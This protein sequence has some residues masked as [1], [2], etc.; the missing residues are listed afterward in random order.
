MRLR[1]PAVGGTETANVVAFLDQGRWAGGGRRR[2]SGFVTRFSLESRPR[3]GRGGLPPIG[4]QEWDAIRAV[5]PEVRGLVP[6]VPTESSVSVPERWLVLMAR[7]TGRP[8]SPPVVVY[9]H[10]RRGWEAVIAYLEEMPAEGLAAVGPAALVGRCFGECLPPTPPLHVLGRVLEHFQN[11]AGPLATYSLEDHRACQPGTVAG[12]IRDD[13]MGERGRTELVRGR[14]TPLARAIYP[15]LATTGPPW[16]R[17]CTRSKTRA[18]WPRTARPD[19][20]SRR[21]GARP[22]AADTDP[23]VNQGKAVVGSDP[24]G[25]PTSSW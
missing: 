1:G 25:T 22:A 4:R 10:Q 23:K 18:R 17:P 15:A 9:S 21:P 13:D 8:A 5:A 16:T 7:D 14:Y 6:S 11:G 2:S 3:S 19:R 20:A 24:G 12:L